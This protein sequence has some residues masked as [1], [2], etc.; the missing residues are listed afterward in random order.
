MSEEN[1]T[2]A[3]N[4][5]KKG[6]I[7]IVDDEPYNVKILERL[8]KK[9][10]YHAVSAVDGLQA[11]NY[12]QK[13][14][15]AIDLILL[16]RMMPNMNG[17]EVMEKLKANPVLKE[18]PVIMQTAA[19]SKDQVIEGIAAG[20]YY[21]LTKPFEEEIMLSIVNSAIEDGEKQKTLKT[22]VQQQREVL[23]K[24]TMAQFKIQNLREAYN[25]SYFLANYFPNAEKVVTGIYAIV[26]NSIEHGHLKITKADKENL[27]KTKGAWFN[28]I[29]RR[30]VLPEN[31]D[32]YVDIRYGIDEESQEVRLY[33]KDQGDG[34]N[35]QEFLNLDYKRVLQSTGRGI[36]RAKMYSFDSIEYLG[37][38]S[39]VL[40]T[41]KINKHSG[42]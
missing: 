23:G 31:K 30:V 42:D 26:T 15:K 39:E 22:K 41:V 33:V 38:G 5:P 20:V 24:M 17:M 3:S 11:W 18:I 14:P 34:F 25:L 27:L 35:W 4:E 9:N 19:G 29:T 12:L 2:Q 21:Y 10:N 13:Y 32:K 1:V 16:D 36:A 6:N 37:T 28:E 8:L 40:C 7:L